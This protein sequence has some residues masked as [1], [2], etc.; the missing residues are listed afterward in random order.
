[1]SAEIAEAYR[2]GLSMRECGERF[3]LSV[4]AVRRRLIRM[5]VPRLEAN[6]E[7]DARILDLR[8][9]GWSVSTIALA[10]NLPHGLVKSVIR[11]KTP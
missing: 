7:R 5:N 1:M 10:M 6:R 3:G 11:R 4:W 2:S 9:Q 8:A